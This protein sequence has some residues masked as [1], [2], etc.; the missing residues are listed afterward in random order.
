MNRHSLIADDE[1]GGAQ[2][3]RGRM[4]LQDG[5]SEDEAALDDLLNEAQRQ[6]GSR[7][8]AIILGFRG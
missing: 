5:D 4:Q 2:A 8:T 7:C 1:T 6:S 3:R